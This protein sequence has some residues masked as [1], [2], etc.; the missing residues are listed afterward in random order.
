[1]NYYLK[2]KATPESPVYNCVLDPAFINKYENAPSAIRP[3]GLRMVEH[4]EKAGI[5]VDTVSDLPLATESPPWL[6]VPPDTDLSLT[7][8]KKSVTP[9]S[10]YKQ[11]FLRISSD[12]Y[13]EH[14][15]I[16]T[17]GS[18]SEEKVAAA[19]VTGK[20]FKS[21]FSE[22]LPDNSSIYSAELRA[23]LLALKSAYQSRQD[24]FLIVS[25]SLSS[26][27]SLASMK[28]THPTL[29]EIHDLHSKVVREGKRI[30]FLWVPSHV[31]I[32]GNTAVDAA[33]KDA[34]GLEPSELNPYVPY[35]D[36]KCLVGKYVH[37]LWQEQWSQQEDNKLFQIMPKLSDGPPV[38][39]PGRKAETVLNRL[40]IGHTYL[41]HSFLLR[42]EDPPFCHACDKTISIR[43]VLTECADL[44]DARERFFNGNSSVRDIFSLPANLIFH[45]LQEVNLFHKL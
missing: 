32:R 24:K 22:R 37:K 10:F 28:L 35:A 4:F 12:K 26:I 19:A 5:D 2:V 36:Y 23:I 6:L 39:A 9:E 15:Y 13:K 14:A 27:Q 34:L 45:F 8:F 3:F 1:M 25:D 16:F 44:V 33:A 21:C 40:L 17:D 30:T 11:E 7:S 38:A 43:H 20:H 31:G 41:T 29:S 18:K 42:N